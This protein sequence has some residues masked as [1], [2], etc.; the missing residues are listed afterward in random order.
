ML[1]IFNRKKFKINL[2]WLLF[3]KLFRASINILLS[4]FLARNLGPESFGV[5]NYLLAFIFLF[6][7]FSSLGMNPVLTNKIIKNKNRNNHISIMNAY[8]L[9]LILS[10]INYFIFIFLINKINI[11]I[12]YYNYSII[13]GAIIIF[14]SSEVLFSYFEA[15]SLSKYISK[16]KCVLV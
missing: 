5:L 3:D 12:I 6:T 15:K 10:L 1:K 4:I 14:K 7:S 16:N 8:Y 13:L 2:S 9:R 11:N